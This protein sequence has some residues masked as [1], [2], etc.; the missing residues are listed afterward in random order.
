MTVVSASTSTW[1]L[2]GSFF[3]VVVPVRRT[4]SRMLHG[5]SA[6]AKTSNSHASPSPCTITF[7]LTRIAN[8]SLP[9]RPTNW[10]MTRRRLTFPTQISAFISV[11]TGS[12]SQT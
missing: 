4:A 1:R 10:T 8:L 12:S 2:N 11:L 7:G 9:P 6:V 3:P 5:H